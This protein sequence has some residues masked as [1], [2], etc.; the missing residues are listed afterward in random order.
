MN[1]NGGTKEMLLN[2]NVKK[3][4]QMF[5]INPIIESKMNMLKLMDK[6]IN[7]IGDEELFDSWLMLGVPDGA[8]DDDYEYMARSE[9]GYKDVCELFVRLLQREID[10]Q[11][12]L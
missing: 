7:E 4:R 9:E 12:M 1:T 8:D 10:D 3:E 11:G 6:M 2:K 5:M